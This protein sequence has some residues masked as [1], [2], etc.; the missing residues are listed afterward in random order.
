MSWMERLKRTQLVVLDVDGTLTDGAMYYS[1][2]GDALKRFYVQDGMGI[3]L[4]QQA[5]IE[6]ALLTGEDTPI[7]AK[8]A[9]KLRINH[10][11]LGCQ[12]KREAVEELSLRLAIPLEHIAYMGDDV[13]DEA[14][15]KVVGVRACPSDAVPVIQL[16]SDYICAKSG[17]KGAVR[18]F[19]ELLLATQGRSNRFSAA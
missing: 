14:P 9:M 13:I 10:V 18:E 1:A 4:L 11:I 3:T 5:G 12:A 6:V 19:A 15:M 8:R 16:V 17:G 2:E 7:V